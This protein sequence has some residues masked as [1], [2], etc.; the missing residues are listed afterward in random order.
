MGLQ[1]HQAQILRTQILKEVKD[2]I[3]C[4]KSPTYTPQTQSCKKKKKKELQRVRD[5]HSNTYLQISYL[6]SCNRDT[7]MLKEFRALTS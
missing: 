3:L 2:L 5:S 7:E 6:R 4:K 1:I